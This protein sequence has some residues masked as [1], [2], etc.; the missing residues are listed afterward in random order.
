MFWF[1]IQSPFNPSPTMPLATENNRIVWVNVSVAL[2]NVSRRIC[3]RTNNDATDGAKNYFLVIFVR[4]FQAEHD[5]DMMMMMI[6]KAMFA[7]KTAFPKVRTFTRLKIP[8]LLITYDCKT[9]LQK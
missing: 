6:Q 8:M 9:I 1:L 7:L 4:E 3:L 5:D 2:Q